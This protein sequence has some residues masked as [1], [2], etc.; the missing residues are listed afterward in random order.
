MALLLLA[1]LLTA[2][3]SLSQAGGN[4]ISPREVYCDI[5][6]NHTLCIHQVSEMSVYG[7]QNSHNLELF[8]ESYG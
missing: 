4:E 7:L 6:E 2:S 5:H 1:S 8:S 3:S